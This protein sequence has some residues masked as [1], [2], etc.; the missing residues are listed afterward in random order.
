MTCIVGIQYDGGVI[1]GGDSASVA[2]WSRTVRADQKVFTNGAYL[3]GFTASWRIGQLLHYS[4]EVPP[5]I[6]AD[7]DRFMATVFVNAVRQTLKAGGVDEGPEFLVGV[8]GQLY[9][10]HP[11]YQVERTLAGYNAVGCGADIALGSLHTT[12]LPNTQPAERIR[13]ALAAAAAWSSGVVEP[14]K[15]INQVWPRS[16]TDGMPV[17]AELSAANCSTYPANTG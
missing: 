7:L 14:F 16:Q 11:T 9:C 3:I 5:I 8:A 10:V 1:I 13:L 4:L 12:D 17:T 6:G 15:A 2:G